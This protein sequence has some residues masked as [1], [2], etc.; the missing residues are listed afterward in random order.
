VPEHDDAE[1]PPVPT[2]SWSGDSSSDSA[3]SSFSSS[4]W[5]GEDS[6]Y[7]HALLSS[8]QTQPISAVSPPVPVWDPEATQVAT[9]VNPPWSEPEPS[10]PSSGPETPR[11]FDPATAPEQ[12]APV[13]LTPPP[14][15]PAGPPPDGRKVPGWA[16]VL[17]VLVMAG[18]AGFAFWSSLLSGELQDQRDAAARQA[19]AASAPV[20][21]LCQRP[22][23]IGQALRSSPDDPCGRATQV[24][25]SPIPGAPGEPGPAG[26]Q[27]APGV[28]GPTGAAGPS[29]VPGPDGQPG[30]QGAAGPTG[31]KGADGDKGATGDKGADGAPGPSG[32]P[33]PDGNRGPDG[34]PGTCPPGST[35]AT[36]LYANGTSGPGCVFTQ[37]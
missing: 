31:A 16:W 17:F 15:L 23:S 20:L 11:G 24:A 34:L 26:V 6:A 9:L 19:V 30:A 14:S 5:P 29:G 7:P 37:E 3:T 4:S 13:Y 36:V 33:G 2:E 28:P 25:T 1:S 18:F 10:P 22:D 12:P 32:A 27:G 8:D 35:Q 21:E